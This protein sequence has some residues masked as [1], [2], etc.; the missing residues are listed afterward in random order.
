MAIQHR[1][2][3]RTGI[4]RLNQSSYGTATAAG[5]GNFRNII[6][7]SQEVGDLDPQFQDD[8]AYDQGS[9]LA[10]DVWAL[11]NSSGLTLSPD[12]NFQDIGYLLKDGLG[13]YAV[14]GAGPYEHVF[15]PQNVNTSRQMPSRTIVKQYGGLKKVMFRDMVQES[16]V[17][18]FGKTGRIKTQATYRG[19]G[20]YAED[21]GSEALP[22]IETDREFAYNGQYSGFTF[23]DGVPNSQAYTCAISVGTLSLNNPAVDDGY[24][25][26]S[27]YLVSGDPESGVVKSEDLVGV[28]EYMFNFTA[29]LDSSDRLRGWL[30][31]GTDVSWA[32]TITGIVSNGHSLALTHDKVRIIEAKEVSEV[33]G[34]I[35]ISGKCQFLATSGVIGFEATLT[36]DVTSYAT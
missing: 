32:T 5:S 22:S 8:A 31:A 24:R 6:S 15:T 17:I 33:D 10:N 34:F 7:D 30:K 9:D 29:R 36:N 27:S 21:R 3:I 13:G 23:T 16:L 20:F 4:G 35:G 11:T 12:F 18:N 25:Q 14:S 26:C 28:R 1:S 2:Q 19:S